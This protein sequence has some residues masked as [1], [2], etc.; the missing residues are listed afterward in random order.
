MFSFDPQVMN[1]PCIGDNEQDNE[2]IQDALFAKR[3]V[4]PVKNNEGM[5]KMCLKDQFYTKK[6]RTCLEESD[7]LG[8]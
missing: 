6:V 7:E 2:R 1:G 8:Q 3:L 4:S 5:S